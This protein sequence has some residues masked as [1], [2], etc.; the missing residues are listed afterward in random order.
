ML[1][2]AGADAAD[3]PEAKAEA[4]GAEGVLDYR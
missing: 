4:E 3:H 2:E 1:Q